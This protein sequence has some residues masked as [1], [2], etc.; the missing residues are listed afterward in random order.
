MHIHVAEGAYVEAGDVLIELNTEALDIDVSQLNDQKEIPETQQEI[1][2][3]IQS[4][5]DVS[6][7]RVADY[8]TA[9]QPSVQAIID[10]HISHQNA[11]SNLENAKANADLNHRIAQ[12]QLEQYQ[13]SGTKQQRKI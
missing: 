3:K 13:A 12:M 2:T 1:Y 7:I 8:D 4:G 11:L 5:A 9:A 10:G 6:S